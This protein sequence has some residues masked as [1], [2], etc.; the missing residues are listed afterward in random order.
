MITASKRKPPLLRCLRAAGACITG[1]LAML[2]CASAATATGPQPQ[3]AARIVVLQSAPGGPY[4]EFTTSFHATLQQLAP[5]R[6]GSVVVTTV[7]SDT[8]WLAA[9]TA[10][11]VLVAV[12]TQATELALKSHGSSPLLSVLVPKAT[13]DRMLKQAA[14]GRTVTAI[15]LDQPLSRYI[16]LAKLVVPDLKTIGVILG[17]T[18]GSQ[19]GALAQATA[20]YSLK[21]ATAGMTDGNPL[22]AL[23]AL[24][25]DSGVILALPDPVVYNRYTL[26]PLLLTTFRY[27]IPVVGFSAALVKAGAVAAVYSRPALIGRQAAEMLQSTPP[28]GGT[29]PRYFD[30]RFNRAVAQALDLALP[31]EAEAKATLQQGGA[32]P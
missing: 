23:S 16:G 29:Y 17:P 10:D 22:P 13:F 2:A 4:E 21:L 20:A 3:T 9:L 32:A 31:S 28:G 7:Q 11:D 27:R 19:A 12:G 18:T 5:A 6:A 8:T 14:A 26:P 1:L 25:E 24:L 30:V 15:Y